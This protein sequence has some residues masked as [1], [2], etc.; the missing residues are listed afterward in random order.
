VSLYGFIYTA[1]PE[2]IV[3]FTHLIPDK[4]GDKLLSTPRTVGLKVEFICARGHG[5]LAAYYQMQLS[6][7]LLSVANN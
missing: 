6:T 1:W 7:Y 3:A 4:H 2:V 5:L